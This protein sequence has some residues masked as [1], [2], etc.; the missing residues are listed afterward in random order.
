MHE[1]EH[2]D[3][4]NRGVDMFLR[5]VEIFVSDP[6]KSKDFYQ[7]VLGFEVTGIQADKYIWLKLGEKEILLRPKSGEPNTRPFNASDSNI[8]LCSNDPADTLQ[9]LKSRGLQVKGHD[10]GCPTFTDLDGN[11][12]QLIG[13]DGSFPQEKI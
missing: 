3:Y 7:N 6:M 10:G 9:L 8:V 4:S 2:S 1:I 13:L 5:H 11:W 12:F